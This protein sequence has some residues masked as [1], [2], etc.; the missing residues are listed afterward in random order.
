M[1]EEKE[2]EEVKEI[3][4]E[5]REE[6]KQEVKEEVK[7]IRIDNFD[8]IRILELDACTNCGECIKWC[9]VIEVAPE[10]TLSISPPAKIRRLRR[11]LTAQYGL[12]RI[13]FGKK[14][15]FFNRLF[16]TPMITKEDVEHFVTDIYACTTCRQCHMVCPAHIETVELW[17]RVRRSLVD[18]EYGPLENHKALILSSRAYD[19]PWQQPR[20]NRARWTK[21]AKKEGRIKEVPKSIKP[22][23]GLAPPHPPI[24]RKF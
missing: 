12:R 6:I 21:V 7:E 24:K 14:N 23:Q 20:S 8:K 16:K 2:V 10:L 1:K 11:I 13:L 19:D 4:E 18:A 5:T 17:E 15:N 22:P 9:P 3:K